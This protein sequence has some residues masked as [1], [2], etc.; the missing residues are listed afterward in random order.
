MILLPMDAAEYS[1]P[2]AAGKLTISLS[3]HPP[4]WEIGFDDGRRQ[5]LCTLNS[6]GGIGISHADSVHRIVPASL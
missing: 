3:C 2:A 4:N 1:G 6:V 5:C